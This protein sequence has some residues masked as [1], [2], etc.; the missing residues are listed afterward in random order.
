M[1]SSRSSRLRAAAAALLLASGSLLFACDGG[2]SRPSA[3]V[4]ATAE[5]VSLYCEAMCG[6]RQRCNAEVVATCIS[7]CEE[8]YAKVA[9]H[10]RADLLRGVASCFA[11]LECDVLDDECVKRAEEDLG[12][13]PEKAVEAP[14]FKACQAKQQ[15]CEGTEFDFSDDRCVTLI[16][17]TSISRPKAAACYQKPCAEVDACIAPYD[18]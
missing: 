13:V 2:L 16:F 14:D 5:D 17:L 1:A 3:S 7:G 4:G 10:V 11:N 8:G 15:E 18:R 9:P 6:L 12:I